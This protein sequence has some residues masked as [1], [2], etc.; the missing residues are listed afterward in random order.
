MVRSSRY[1]VHVY[2]DKNTV[3]PYVARTSS[4]HGSMAELKRPVACLS[5]QHA[6]NILRRKLLVDALSQLKFG[7]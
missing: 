1:K 7:K 5:I 6:I 4:N 2:K 3:L